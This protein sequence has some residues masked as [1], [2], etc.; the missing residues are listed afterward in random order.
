MCR[1]RSEYITGSNHSA[2][3]SPPHIRNFLTKYRH[4][5]LLNA[6]IRWST[7]A[8]INPSGRVAFRRSV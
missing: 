6:L 1:G 3:A 5:K 2:V 8:T 4:T 7:L